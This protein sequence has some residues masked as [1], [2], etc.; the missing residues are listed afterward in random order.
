MI[1]KQ[2]YLQSKRGVITKIYG[3]QKINS[4]KRNHPLPDYTNKELQEW[5]NSK[6]EF[7]ILYDLWVQ[8]NF[9]KLKKPSVDRLENSKPYIFNNMEITTWEENQLRAY[10]AM[11]DGTIPTQ[12]KQTPIKMFD[13]NGVLIKEFPSFS[14]A[15]RETG[16]NISTMILCCKGKKESTSGYIWKY[17]N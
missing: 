6:E 9:D 14:Q 16:A 12:K 2:K 10:K 1:P 7:H 3:Q 13:L 4:K 8:S 15:K 11:R 17:K 5:M